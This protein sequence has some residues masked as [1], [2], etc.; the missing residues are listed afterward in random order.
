MVR[1]APVHDTRLASCHVEP[2]AIFTCVPWFALQK[3]VF[4]DLAIVI[5][6]LAASDLHEDDGL[7]VICTN[8]CLTG[9]C[10]WWSRGETCNGPR[11]HD[12]QLLATVVPMLPDGS[13]TT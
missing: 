8:G 2:N 6:F 10:V 11:T 4:A 1:A 12:A 9:L 13:A 7:A 3:G 5:S